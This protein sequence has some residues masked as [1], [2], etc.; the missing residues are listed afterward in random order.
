MKVILKMKIAGLGTV[1]QEISV[2]EQRAFS[3]VMGG[4][5]R[6]AENIQAET[7]YDRRETATMKPVEKRKRGR[8]KN[9]TLPE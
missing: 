9:K 4:L 1:G 8:K 7:E 3:L 2:S 5:A 6:Y